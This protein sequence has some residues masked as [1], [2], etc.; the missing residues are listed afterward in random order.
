MSP[1][2]SLESR[3]MFAA[4]F[5][6]IVK[7]FGTNG[8]ATA[9]TIG[10]GNNGHVEALTLSSGKSL[11]GVGGGLTRF[12]ADG[13]VDATFGTSGITLFKRVSFID[14]AVDSSGDIY[15]LVSAASGTL[16][17]RYTAAGRLDSTFATGGSALVESSA[18]FTARALDVQADGK[19]VV[20]GTLQ[21]SDSNVQ[22]TRVYRLTTGGALD[23]NFGTSGKVDFKLGSSDLLLPNAF[24]LIADV[25]VLSNGK[26]EVAGASFNGDGNT[27]GDGV[28]ALA[29]LTSGGVLDSSFATGGVARRAAFDD[30]ALGSTTGTIR[31][32]GSALV[33]TN[34]SSFSS[35][36]DGRTNFVGFSTSGKALFNAYV[37][38]SSNTGL[39][40][41]AAPLADGRVALVND[42]GRAWLVGTDGSIS[43]AVQPV[44]TS[45]GNAITTSADGALLLATTSDSNVNLAKIA[46][47]R[48]REV[49]PDNLPAASVIA[50]AADAT[51]GLHVAFFDTASKTL[52][53]AYRNSQGYWGGIRTVDGT[54]GAGAAIS[55]DTTQAKNRTNVAIAYYDAAN[56][57]LKLAFSNTN[58]RKFGF[59]TVATKGNVGISPSLHYTDSGGFAVS[60]YSKTT[61]SL[62]YALN[63]GTGWTTDTVATG[64]SG[65]WS[66]LQFDPSTRRP[67]IAYTGP[68]NT[69]MYAL[70][71]KVTGWNSTTLATTKSG[72]A[73]V[74][75]AL[76]N[77]AAYGPRVTY[78]DLASADF[79]Y[80][81]YY[82]YATPRNQIQTIASRGN[83]GAYSDVFNDG[84][85]GS[86]L[87]YAW[88]R[89]A[90][91]IVSYSNVAIGSVPVATTV[92]TGGG[93]NLSVAFDPLSYSVDAIAYTDTA[94]GLT[95][96]R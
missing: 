68:K 87:A 34:E 36:T 39:P 21:G 9:P 43:N 44:I 72:A 81:N 7:G 25:H 84:Y 37:S 12:N 75:L 91:A 60:F 38:S 45:G 83:V 92:A 19:V 58:G 16:I 22:T 8:V 31:D 11:V 33:S 86:T 10:A 95:F 63:N 62:Y 80:A 77:Y 48:I 79:V 28:V 50:T 35:S 42:L 71:D 82:R 20:A 70:K 13:S 73:F 29:R 78:Y 40:V 2:E 53:Y 26:I 64:G 67:A 88:S 47:G 49:R 23:S 66:D 41:D 94:S 55:I 93:R 17:Q 6:T 24:D 1:I 15:V 56:G 52:K 18:T 54:V 5:G 90:D 46:A 4:V 32:D 65:L 59:E 76:P 96:V 61:Q 74:N 3:K 69:V 51:G 85:G 27:Y 14:D 30:V 57:D 89:S